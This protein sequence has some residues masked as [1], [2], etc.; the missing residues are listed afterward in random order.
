MNELVVGFEDGS[1][2]CF[3]IPRTEKS[4]VGG[5]LVE[6]VKRT[7]ENLGAKEVQSED[8]PIRIGGHKGA[9]SK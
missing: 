1:L 8:E 2:W 6:I 3:D 9:V 5:K 4:Q 7:M